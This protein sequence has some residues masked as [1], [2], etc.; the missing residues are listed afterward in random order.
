MSATVQR[1]IRLASRLEAAV[2]SGQLVLHYQPKLDLETRALVGVE[3]LARWYDL[4]L[5]WVSPS[6]FIPLAEERGLIDLLGDWAL[7]RAVHDYRRWSR[8]R[9]L[10]WRVAVNVSARQLAQAGF[11]AHAEAVVREAG[12]TPDEVELELTETA[13]ASDPEQAC[14]V[15]RRL[16]DAGFSLA[17]DDFGTGY[18][19]LPSCTASA[20]T[21]SR[22]TSASSRA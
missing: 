1:R 10:P 2:R 12:A 3:A 4:E 15:A 11:A 9:P 17:L 6:E 20:W 19:S 14:L 16:A 21:S 22:S 7:S 18:S 8:R 13:M 5:G